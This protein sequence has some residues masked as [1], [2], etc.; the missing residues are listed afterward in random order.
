MKAI[1]LAG[2]YGTRISEVTKEIPKPMIRIGDKPLLWHIMKIYSYYKIDDFIICMGYK[3]EIIKE[4][5][6][7]IPEPWNVKLVDTGL[8][9][10]TGGRIKK[11]K[12]YVEN[13]S[14]CLTYGD[15]LKAIDIGRLISFHKQKKKLVT[16]TAAKPPG[17]YGI[18]TLENDG[19]IAITEKP[20]GDH[21]WINGG[22]Y[23]LE[24]GIFDYIRGD[25]TIWEQEPLQRLASENQISAYRYEGYYQPM[26][27][28]S[29]Q[30][31]L[32]KLWDSG[33]PYWKIWK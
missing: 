21:N 7:E 17:R 12:K 16:L 9:T 14:F 25:T 4:Y 15:D 19:V 2:G 3:S 6:Q 1:I 26:D 11:I 32:E 22:Y 33:N 23:V 28:F 18:L 5:F 10:M 30:T 31:I 27:T 24:P 29:D 13:E 20:P 8:D